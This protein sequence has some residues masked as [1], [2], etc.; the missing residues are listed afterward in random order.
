MDSQPDKIL[1]VDCRSIRDLGN[2]VGQTFDLDALRE[3]GVVDD[4]G[5]VID[6]VDARQV[7]YEDGRIE[8]TLD[9]PTE[10]DRASD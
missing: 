2:S 10:N 3:L 8:V 4:D 6:G 1:S 9:P 5:N 7:I